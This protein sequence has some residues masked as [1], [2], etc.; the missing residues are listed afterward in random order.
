MQSDKEIGV[1]YSIRWTTSYSCCHR[2]RRRSPLFT[3]DRKLSG[4]IP[5]LDV[6]KN[7][8]VHILG[9]TSTLH[10]VAWY[11]CCYHGCC[12]VH[13]QVESCEVWKSGFF[14]PHKWVC[15]NILLPTR[16]PTFGN[17]SQMCGT[18]YNH[19][20]CYVSCIYNNDSAIH[21]QHVLCAAVRDRDSAGE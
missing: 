13:T 3:L 12:I 11:I 2:V 6:M 20:D 8:L 18:H 1:C 15:F 21:L 17:C 4:S 10:S 19:K 16:T 7:F 5:N 9:V 14:C